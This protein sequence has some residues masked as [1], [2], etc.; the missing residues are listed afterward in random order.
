MKAMATT[1]VLSM[2]VA[3]FGLAV[4][5]N[6]KT[7]RPC[8]RIEF[9]DMPRQMLYGDPVH[10][11]KGQPFAKDMTVIRH[12]GRYLMYYSVCDFPDDK[13]P[14]DWIRGRWGTGLAVSTNLTDWTRIGDI[15]IE[16]LPAVYAGAAPCVK[17]FGGKIHI[18]HQQIFKGNNVIW[19]ATSD[20]GLTFRC[21]NP[22]PA[23][24]PHNRWSIE[25]AIDAEVYRVGDRLMLMYA[26][27]EHPTKEVQQL[28]M[29][30]A[31]WGS[32]YDAGTWTEMT[33][34]KPFFKPERTWEMHCI[35]APTVYFRKGIWYLFYA[36]A[37]N[38]EKQ[39][40]G[41]AWSSDGVAFTRYSDHPVFPH[42]P[43]GSW[44]AAESGH[45]G[46]FVDDDEQVYLFFQGK[47]TQDGNYRLSCVKVRFVD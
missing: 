45:P 26:T 39:Q 47:A 17:K 10:L 20:D 8:A 40:I 42:G 44:N 12:G 41:V 21:A 43:E 7:E 5:A 38:H 34:D 9:E 2:A 18:F 4:S 19:H 1:K 33:L 37:Y 6:G 14:K 11:R 16:G 29:A 24:V 31:P 32:S 46:I 35:E 22:E 23:F 27:R 15:K 13:R 30:W 25:R 36:G 3:L 28:G